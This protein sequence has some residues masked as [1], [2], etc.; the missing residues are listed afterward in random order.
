MICTMT[1]KAEI[2]MQALGIHQ[3]LPNSISALLKNVRLGNVF[4]LS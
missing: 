4:G 2:A 1:A 3:R